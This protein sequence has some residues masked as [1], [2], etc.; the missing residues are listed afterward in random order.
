MLSAS[1]WSTRESFDPRA[2]PRSRKEADPNIL[3]E[4]KWW[5]TPVSS[6]DGIICTGETLKALV[7]AAVTL[8]D[9]GKKAGP[10]AGS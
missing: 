10:Q 8:N 2:D 3:E 9:S 4:W 1:E 5:G 6:H 7:R